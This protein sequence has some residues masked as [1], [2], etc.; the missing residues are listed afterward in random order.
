LQYALRQFAGPVVFTMGLLLLSGL[1]SFAQQDIKPAQ[2]LLNPSD[3][4]EQAPPYTPITR[5]QKYVYSLEQM[6]SGPHLAAILTHSAFDQVVV[7]PHAWGS[8][9]PSYGIRV[10]SDFGRSFLRA[11]VATG[12]RDLDHEDPRYFYSHKKSNWERTK[13]A[14][15]HTFEV[16][17]DN[18]SM[19]PAYSRL[20]G[21]I[22]MPF[23]AQTWKPGGVNA[24]DALRS[25]AIATGISMG[26][27]VALEFWPDVKHAL[28][29]GPGA[30]ALV[31]PGTV[32]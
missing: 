15:Q 24:P 2:A 30:A 3:A 12:I 10:A 18:G 31:S 17:N 29:L 6:F 13:Y 20:I 5:K 27:T 22:G 14:I 4:V 25:G 16:H 8:N 23:I 19:M 7:V 1:N 26:M 11:T 9:A 21:D 28:H 32:H